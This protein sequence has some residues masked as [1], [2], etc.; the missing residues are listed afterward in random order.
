MSSSGRL[1]ADMMM[2]MMMILLTKFH[3][4]LVD[5]CDPGFYSLRANAAHP[6]GHPSRN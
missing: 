5:E 4:K 6:T 1:S 2:M 3:E